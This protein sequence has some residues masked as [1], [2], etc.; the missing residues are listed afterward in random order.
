MLD[1]ANKTFFWRKHLFFIEKGIIREKPCYQ[2]DF[3]S[4]L[5]TNIMKRFFYRKVFDDDSVG[6]LGVDVARHVVLQG[7]ES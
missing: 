4:G 1:Q 5:N 2:G 6:V 7:S 3:C